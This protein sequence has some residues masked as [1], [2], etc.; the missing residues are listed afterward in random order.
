MKKFALILNLFLL[1][2]LTATPNIAYSEPVATAP[3][4]IQYPTDLKKWQLISTSYRTDNNT[5]RAILGN[6]IAI[7]AAKAG[8]IN[9]WP[10][11]TV[12]AK[13]VWNNM[14][15][16]QWKAALVPGDFV[17]SEIMVKDAK[18][19]KSTGGWGYARWKGESQ[20][21]HGKDEDFSQTCAACHNQ[22]KDSD[23]VF[24]IP[25]LIP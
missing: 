20:L 3:N 16:P 23:F 6:N 19:Y 2:F 4:G 5:Q 12:L 22:A 17:H 10:K 25:S 9:P 7:A 14:E 15:H 1:S 24:T 21:P 11:G 8:N 18:K 13:L